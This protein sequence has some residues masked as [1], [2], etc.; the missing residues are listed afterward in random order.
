M[1]KVL[2]KGMVLGGLIFGVAAC[3][4]ESGAVEEAQETNEEM[5]EDTGMEDRMTDMSEFMTKAASG[6]MMEVE[7]GKLAQEK[8]QMQEVKD[9]GQMMVTDHSAANEKL[10][11]LAAQKNIVLPDSMGEEHMDHVQELRNMTGADFDK[12]Y[13]SLMVDDHQKDID[14]FEDAAND[15]ED[16]EVKSFASNTVPTLR[17]HLDRAKEVKNMVDKKM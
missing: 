10:K 16:P 14:M 6:G 17:K 3:N 7:L 12:A 11:A 5:A 9:F 1:K 13:I 4:Q 2:L 15:L 8:G